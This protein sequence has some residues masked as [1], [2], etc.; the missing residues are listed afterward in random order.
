MAQVSV[1]SEHAESAAGAHFAPLALTSLAVTTFFLGASQAGLF[2]ATAIIGLVLFFGG[3]VQLIV[4]L[5]EHRSGN[6]VDA[7]AFATH[8]GFWMAFGAAAYIGK[9]PGGHELGYF[10]L[11]WTVVAGIVSL[12]TTRANLAHM[13]TFALFF[14][15]FLALTIGAFLGANSIFTTIGG[16]IGIITAIVAGYTALASLGS[17]FAL[18]TGERG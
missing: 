11:A 5:W 15:T 10:F 9:L 7:H 18:P 8:G 2:S 1:S 14:L 12:T 6:A 16:W 3:L 17:P 13:A 4:G